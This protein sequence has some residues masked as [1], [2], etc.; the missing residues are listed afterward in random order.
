MQDLFYEKGEEKVIDE[1]VLKFSF[2]I[3]VLNLSCFQ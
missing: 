2:K 1:G 3:T